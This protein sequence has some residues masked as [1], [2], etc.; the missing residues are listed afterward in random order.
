MRGTVPSLLLTACMACSAAPAMAQ[1]GKVDMDAGSAVELRIA[2]V[3]ASNSGQ[4]F[5]Q[6]LASFRRQFDSLFQYS[7]YRLL[8]EERRRV[9]WRREAEF[10]LPH[11]RYLVVIPRGYK[12]GRVSLNLML[13]QG[14]RPLLNT[15]L[16]LRNRGT[17]L[18]GGPHHGDGVLIIAIGA[19]TTR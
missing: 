7:S 19:A 13:M 4:N 18:V 9:E 15:V 8:R 6:R 16:A 1:S 10:Q 2:A 17:F 14:S 3:V 12:D 11:G 5:D